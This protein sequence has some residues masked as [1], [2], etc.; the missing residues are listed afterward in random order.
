MWSFTTFLRDNST[1]T[2]TSKRQTCLPYVKERSTKL[3]RPFIEYPQL[4]DKSAKLPAVDNTLL[5]PLSCILR[6]VTADFKR[7][8]IETV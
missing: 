2:Q 1:G 4:R 8:F 7:K 5:T 3:V 6:S